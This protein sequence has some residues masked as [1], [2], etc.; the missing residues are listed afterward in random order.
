MTVRRVQAQAMEVHQYSHGW[1]RYK[2][3]FGRI[4]KASVDLLQLCRCMYDVRCTMDG[5][6]EGGRDIN[7]GAFP[8]SLRPLFS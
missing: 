2:L 1:E 3:T 6:R 5:G 4:R 8:Y 7:L